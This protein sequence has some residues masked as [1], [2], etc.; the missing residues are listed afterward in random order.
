MM[1]EETKVLNPENDMKQVNKQEESAEKKKG[2]GM[3][4]RFAA[5]AAGAAIGTGAVLAAGKIYEASAEDV[6]EL[7]EAEVNAEEGQDEASEE[8]AQVEE[9]KASVDPE[10]QHTVVEHVVT[11]KVETAAPQ[12]EEI[13]AAPEDANVV[14]ATPEPAAQDDEVHV[15]GVAVD[16]NGMGG[17]ATFVGVQLGD[18]AAMLVDVETD[19]TVDYVVYDDNHDGTIQNNEWHGVSH[20]GI[21]T[22]QAVKA[23]VEEAHEHGE[24]AVATNIQTGEQCEIVE[25][26]GG[27]GMASLDEPASCECDDNMPDYVN[28]ANIV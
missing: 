13:P 24:M 14:A 10:P 6:E 21:S 4:A 28:D 18:D 8:V 3:G 16:D 2:T 11:V 17:V 20:E 12:Q 7:E 19:G 23:Y 5:T 26:E 25:T 27:Y 22:V 1:N 15:V 9:V